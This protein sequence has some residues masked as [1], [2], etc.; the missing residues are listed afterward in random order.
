M[1]NVS[2]YS[3][4]LLH[5][6]AINA[7]KADY[8][9]TDLAS[10]TENDLR[11]L[12]R[13]QSGHAFV[14]DVEH[15]VDCSA[16]PYVPAGYTVEKHQKS[17]TWKSGTSL[18]QMDL[19]LTDD[20]MRGVSVEGHKLHEELVAKPVL[21]ANVLDYLLARRHL[22]PETLEGKRVCFWGTVYRYSNGN[23]YVRCLSRF[24]GISDY[25]A[26]CLDCDFRDIHPA[27]MRTI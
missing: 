9:P 13:I 2:K 15:V 12:K 17:D 7:A 24:R 10:I 19:Y 18:S 22:I 20:Q 3:I 21:N 11:Q 16:D 23:L 1:N 8:S 6:L 4:G 27:A 26:I 25:S 5:E 14:A